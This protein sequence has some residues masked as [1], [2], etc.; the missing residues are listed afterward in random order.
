MGTARILAVLAIIAL[1][2]R[3]Y[4][5]SNRRLRRTAAQPIHWYYARAA[6]SDCWCRTCFGRGWRWRLLAFQTF[7]QDKLRFHNSKIAGPLRRTGN[8]GAQ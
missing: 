3:S 1:V 5:L 8:F 2:R 7:P 6:R 4:C